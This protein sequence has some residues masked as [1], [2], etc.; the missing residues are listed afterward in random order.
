MK[1]NSPSHP[2]PQSF[3]SMKLETN[4]TYSPEMFYAYMNTSK[5]VLCICSLSLCIHI[6][7]STFFMKLLYTYFY[8]LFCFL[9]CETAFL[10]C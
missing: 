3:P 8:A 2:S 1:N 7:G 4:F 5:Y 9:N 10:N 6:Y